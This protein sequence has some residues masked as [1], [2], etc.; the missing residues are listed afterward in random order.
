MAP[1][2]SPSPERRADGFGAPRP[3]RPRGFTL[4]EMLV[5]IAIIGILAA[6]VVTVA[7]RVTKGGQTSSTRDILR[8]LDSVLTEHL[9]TRD[10][11]P[12]PFVTTDRTML[13]TDPP[14]P[15]DPR[16][17]YEK[18][19][20]NQYVFPLFDGRY[21][22]RAF[23]MVPGGTGINPRFDQLYD[24]AQPSA[25]L[26]LL[27]LL[28]NDDGASQ[29]LKGLPTKFVQRHDV[30]AYGWLID[31]RSNEPTGSPVRRRLR[32]PVFLDA[33]GNPIRFVHPRFASGYG[34]FYIGGSR[35]DRLDSDDVVPVATPM[36]TP[37]RFSRS[38]RPFMLGGPGV[39]GNAVGDA[40]EGI[41]GRGYFYSSGPDG[42][43]G[44]RDD[45]IYTQ[46]PTFPP[47]TNVLH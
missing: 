2:P 6:L 4:V 35:T 29:S 38:F 37:M 47:E 19:D 5:V 39:G 21:T 9:A 34:A 33:F 1:H 41:G 32:I 14:V 15:D 27:G 45:N 17:E 16:L 18:Y 22:N 3:A 20:S 36:P 42:D 46:E 26:F 43:P 23:P 7:G 25:T 8:S 31:P 24:P 13:I 44:T 28:S 30:W 40:D 12:S 11:P 10:A